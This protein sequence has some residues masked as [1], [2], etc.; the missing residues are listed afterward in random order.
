VFVM[1]RHHRVTTLGDSKKSNTVL[2]LKRLVK[3]ILK[4][5]P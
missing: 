3:G 2:E 4:W 1:I 5:P